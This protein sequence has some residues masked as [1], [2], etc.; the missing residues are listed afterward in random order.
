MLHLQT[1]LS[2][3]NIFSELPNLAITSSNC[4]NEVDCYLTTGVEDVKDAL[5]WW[6]ERQKSFP[7]LSYMV[8]Y[9]L[10][11]PGLC[12]LCCLLL[13]SNFELVTT[14][15]VEGVFSQGHLILH[16]SQTASHSSQ[17]MHCSMLGFGAL[18]A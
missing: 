13:M 14:V 15:D 9:Y 8:H 18:F 16:M 1:Y 12:P 7:C 6:F 5:S 11:I 4:H 17:C 3:K 2:A 10:S